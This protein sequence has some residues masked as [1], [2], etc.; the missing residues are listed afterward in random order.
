MHIEYDDRGMPMKLDNF[1]PK[2]PR[3]AGEELYTSEAQ[4]LWAEN[5]RRFIIISKAKPPS[6]SG[7]AREYSRADMDQMFNSGDRFSQMNSSRQSL[8]SQQRN[9]SERVF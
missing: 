5:G 1:N 4:R 6:K 2:D 3:Y 8:D 9:T 7:L